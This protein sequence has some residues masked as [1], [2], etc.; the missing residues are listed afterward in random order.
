MCDYLN[1][2][3]IYS[4]IIKSLI[5]SNYLVI[6]LYGAADWPIKGRWFPIGGGAW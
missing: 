3:I 4:S 2:V 1:I 6:F 5:V